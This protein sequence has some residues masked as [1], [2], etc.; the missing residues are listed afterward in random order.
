MEPSCAAGKL[1]AQRRQS[2][3]GEPP[4]PRLPPL[5]EDAGARPVDRQPQPRLHRPPVE[6]PDVGVE[7]APQLPRNRPLHEQRLLRR[8]VAGGE[9]Q[10]L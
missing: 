6:Q 2:P 10:E 3:P 9:V 8:T 7:P 5:V 1:V 4:L